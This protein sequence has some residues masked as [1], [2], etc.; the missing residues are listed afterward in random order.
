MV[1]RCNL[2]LQ[3]SH[4]LDAFKRRTNQPI[5]ETDKS[6][7]AKE[8]GIRIIAFD[9]INQFF[10]ETTG[11]DLNNHFKKDDIPLANPVSSFLF[12]PIEPERE[13]KKPLY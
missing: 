13:I 12:R 4:V 3:G 2:L 6:K 7:K 11:K 8:K 5:E 10:E 9:K 1:V